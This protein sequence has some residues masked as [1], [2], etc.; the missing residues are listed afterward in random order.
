[1]AN[2]FFHGLPECYSETLTDSKALFLRNLASCV[3]LSDW[4]TQYFL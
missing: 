2:G 3:F 4:R 1:M